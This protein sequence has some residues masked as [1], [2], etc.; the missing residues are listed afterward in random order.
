MFQVEVEPKYRDYVIIEMMGCYTL[1]YKY[2]KYQSPKR[3]II[4]T[5]SFKS[6]VKMRFKQCTKIKK[7]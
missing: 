2:I 7:R 3:G 4:H 5:R 6:S 1:T